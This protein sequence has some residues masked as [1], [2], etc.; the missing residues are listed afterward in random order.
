MAGYTIALIW[1]V[2]AVLSDFIAG[3]RGVRKTALRTILFAVLGPLAIPFVYMM[4][5][6][7]SASSE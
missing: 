6:E 7:K 2:G 4:R 1:V 5:P 3:K